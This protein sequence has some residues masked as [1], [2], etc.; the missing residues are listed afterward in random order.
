MR[1]L[2]PGWTCTGRHLVV[3][4]ARVTAMIVNIEEVENPSCACRNTFRRAH[5]SIGCVR[6][7]VGR[8]TRR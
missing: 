1:W 4:Q 2:T 3:K 5:T 7:S 8:C 6:Q